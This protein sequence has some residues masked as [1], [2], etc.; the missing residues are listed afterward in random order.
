[1]KKLF[2]PGVWVNDCRD[3]H[4]ERHRHRGLNWCKYLCGWS[5]DQVNYLVPD[6]AHWG[7]GRR[8]FRRTT[9]S[10][11]RGRDGWLIHCTGSWETGKAESYIHWKL[12]KTASASRMQWPELELCQ[13]S[14]I[15]LPSAGQNGPWDFYFYSFSITTARQRKQAPKQREPP[16]VIFPLWGAIPIPHKLLTLSPWSLELTVWLLTSLPTIMGERRNC[17]TKAMCTEKGI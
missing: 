13:D 8:S 1:M 17:P 12:H 4:R 10:P 15:R 9:S 3:A 14:G 11:G 2:L 5:L 16:R 7:K 6:Q